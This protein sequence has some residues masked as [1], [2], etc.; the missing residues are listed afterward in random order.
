MAGP[1]CGGCN[2]C[3]ENRWVS[4]CDLGKLQDF[5]LAGRR[6]ADVDV[7]VI[8]VY[9]AQV[10]LLGRLQNGAALLQRAAHSGVTIDTMHY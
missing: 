1:T 9:L 7:N 2:V 6:L 4:G 8:D 3:S 5:L 10:L